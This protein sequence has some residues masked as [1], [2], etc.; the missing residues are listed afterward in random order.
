MNISDLTD[1]FRIDFSRFSNVAMDNQ[2]LNSKKPCLRRIQ[3]QIKRGFF[4]TGH[5]TT[6]TLFP[7]PKQTFN[8]FIR[9]F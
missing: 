6:V 2:N 7:D 8:T 1:R 9:Q 4:T 5:G 3:S